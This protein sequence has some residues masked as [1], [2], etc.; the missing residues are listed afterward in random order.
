[1][2]LVPLPSRKKTIGCHWIY[3]ITVGLDGEVDR[4]KAR[5]MAKGYTQM[6]LTIVTLLLRWPK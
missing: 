1:M 5:L 2:K 3:A 4:L 6:G